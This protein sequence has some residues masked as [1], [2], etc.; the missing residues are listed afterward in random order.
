MFQQDNDTKHI[1]KLVLDVLTWLETNQH[2]FHQ[3]EPSQYAKHVNGTKNMS[4]G[5]AKEHL[6][7]YV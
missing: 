3:L 7:K 5:R 4:E 6:L 1:T 2:Q